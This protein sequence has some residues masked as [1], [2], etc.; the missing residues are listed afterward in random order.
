MTA[1]PSVHGSV[2]VILLVVLGSVLTLLAQVV[3]RRARRWWSD[4]HTIV[5]ESDL[6]CDTLDVPKGWTLNANGYR[7]VVRGDITC[8]GRIRS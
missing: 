6:Y 2:T 3:A 1:A 5:L 4:R 7:V 8:A